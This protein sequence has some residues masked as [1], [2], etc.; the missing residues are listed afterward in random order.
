M[1]VI[2]NLKHYNDF[3]W[4]FYKY[5]SSEWLKDLD[6]HFDMPQVLK[7]KGAEKGNVKDLSK[8][9]EA[10]GPFYIK[11]GQILSAEVQLLP[12]EYDEALQ[13]LQDNATPMPYED[14]EEVIFAELGDTPQHLFTRFNK[15]PLSA[16]SLGQVHVA[17]LASGEAVGVKVQRK[18]IQDQILEQLNAL[19]QLTQ[20]LEEKTEWG[21]RYHVI[22]KFE[23]LKTTLLNE[24]DYTKEASNLKTINN[25]LKEFE[26][27]I[28]P[29]PIDQYCTSRVLTMEFIPGKKITD[30]SIIKKLDIDGKELAE[31]LFRAFLKQIFVDGFFQMD[32]HPGNIYLTNVEGKPALALFDMGMVS[33]IPF[34]LQGEL[35]RCLF[36]MSESREMEV[37][38]ILISLGKKLPE[39]NEYLF[40]SKISD[41]IAS[42]RGQ[43]LK[44]VSLGVIVLKLSYIAAESGLWL[45]IQ[46]SMIGKTLL[47]LSPVL[48]A[49]DSEFDPNKIFKENA[50]ELM[51]QRIQQQLNYQ[52]FYSSLLQGIE[53]FKNLPGRLND[54]FNFLS[55]NDFEVKLRFTELNTL[56][57]NF[58]KIANRITMGLI[59]ASL[60]IS[61]ALLMQIDTPFRL[62]GY[63][64][65]AMSLFLMAAI[66]S[67]CLILTIIF[68][69]NK[70][71]K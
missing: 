1:A 20:F 37:E 59:L 70:K 23:K 39:F 6:S 4:L 57:K 45:P 7:E 13:N 27:L 71:E 38:K 69:D 66:G 46:F 2:S 36:A 22:E 24:L 25:N 68:S 34:Q 48:K 53:F 43:T 58:E 52:T 28:I 63:P 19:E 61:A 12:P 51:N 16:A 67:I 40:R 42:H 49:L 10:L 54:L 17:V 21:K 47:S 15:E 55:N 14:V 8:D 26:R 3:L 30:L 9:L 56:S 50:T 62:F 18:G 32:P 41:A 44:Q 60:V 65:F 11:L 5:G 35:I 64:G 31:D 29:S 33:Y